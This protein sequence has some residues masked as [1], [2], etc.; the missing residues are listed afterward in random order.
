MTTTMALICVQN[1]GADI[2]EAEARRRQA[3]NK[4]LK[5]RLMEGSTLRYFVI[6]IRPSDVESTSIGW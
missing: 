6:G 2:T 4:T 1:E 5:E 3:N